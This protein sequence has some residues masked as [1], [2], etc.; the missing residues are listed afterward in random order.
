[1]HK[2]AQLNLRFRSYSP[3]CAP[4]R[5]NAIDLNLPF[6]HLASDGIY[7]H[8][9]DEE[10]V[11]R[12]DPVL[13]ARFMDPRFRQEARRRIVATY[14]PADEQVALY[15]ALGMPMP[16]SDEL[17]EVRQDQAAY[18][19]QIS[20]GRDARFKVSVISGYHFTCALTGYRLIASKSTY[21]PLEA[22]HIHAH[23]KRGPDTPVNGLALTP[24]AHDLFDAGLW[25]VDDNLRISVAKSDIAESILPGGSH[26]KLADLHG[27]P[28][29]F[30]PQ[31]T[32]RPDP[33]HLAWHRREVFS[34]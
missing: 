2:D 32:L 20:R 7:T 9:G 10:R 6:R 31:A 34:K 17:S 1:V 33:V 13:L 30:A 16:S 25:T 26:F 27:R 5:G 18:K 15:A 22:A 3:I 28:L 11:V 19:V 21:V 29:S 14:F 23:S 24:T 12:L 8:V 4:R